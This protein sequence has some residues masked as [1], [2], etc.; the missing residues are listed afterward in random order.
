MGGKEVEAESVSISLKYFA[1]EEKERWDGISRGDQ[2]KKVFFF[3]H[4][5]FFF[6]ESFFLKTWKILWNLACRR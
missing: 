4:L 1:V 5:V 3:F 6:F 2:I